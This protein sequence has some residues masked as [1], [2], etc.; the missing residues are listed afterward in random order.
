MS[1]TKPVSPFRILVFEVLRAKEF[2]ELVQEKF[3]ALDEEKSKR[4]SI[5]CSSKGR[6][7]VERRLGSGRDDSGR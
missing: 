4:E 7:A 2:K 3:S 6:D 1:N 5:I